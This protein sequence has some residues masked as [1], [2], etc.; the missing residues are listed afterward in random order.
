MSDWTEELSDEGRAE[1]DRFVEHFRRSTVEQMAES[2]FVMSIVPTG[3]F[4]V[5]FAVELGAA[6]MMDKPIMAIVQ[7]GANVPE[8]LRRVC[9]EVVEADIDLEEGRKKIT[10]AIDR[11]RKG[12]TS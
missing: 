3:E 10:A 12:G 1:W 6:V 11:L 5:K 2:A 8:K 4:D 7:P 9:E